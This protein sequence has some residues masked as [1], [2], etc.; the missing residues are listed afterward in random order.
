MNSHFNDFDKAQLDKH[1][2]A[3]VIF[4]R[5]EFARNQVRLKKCNGNIIRYI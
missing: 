4:R 2:Y 1:G 5:P 3:H